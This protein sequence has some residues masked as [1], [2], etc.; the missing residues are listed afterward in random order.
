M[1]VVQGWIRQQSATSMGRGAVAAEHLCYGA[2]VGPEPVT[3]GRGCVLIGC[4]VV[5]RGWAWCGVRYVLC[6]VAAFSGA[7]FVAPLAAG[8]AVRGRILALARHEIGYRE[9]GN[10]CTIFGPCEEWCSLFVTWVWRHAGVPVPSLAFTGYV[11]DWAKATTFIR[12]AKGVP[13]PGDAVLFGTGPSSVSTSLHVGVVEAAYPGYLVTIEGDSL[14]GVRR[15]VVPVRDPR[16]IGEPG[17]IYAYA[18]PLSTTSGQRT[19]A[20]TQALATAAALALADLRN[21]PRLATHPPSLQ[22]SRLL[23]TIAAL[24]AFQHMPYRTGQAQINWTAVDSKGLVEV[25][26]AS[27]MPVSYARSQW[28]Q[29]LQRFND[30][31]HAYRV[32]FRAPPDAPVNSLAPS[33]VGVP[34]QGQVLTESHG[35][36]SNNPTNYSYRWQDCDSSGNNCAPIAAAT[37]QTYKPTSTDVGHT[38]R[39][40]ETASNGGRSGQ[41]ATSEPTAPISPSPSPLA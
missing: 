41:P 24:R 31:G 21:S 36:W 33:I 23:R 4:R 28:Q 35:V 7:L 39:V 20:H 34:Q 37:S 13:E 27:G 10:Y 6:C 11:Y 16:S 25:T 29:F 18:S 30:S 2:R 8:S 22:Q 12:G 1:R 15:F 17:P 14:H 19:P 26:V 3:S 9:P 40:Q 5:R 32:T 38:I